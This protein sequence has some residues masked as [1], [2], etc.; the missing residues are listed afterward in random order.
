M[1]LVFAL[2]LLIVV[3]FAGWFCADMGVFDPKPKRREVSIPDRKQRFAEYVRGERQLM[4]EWE[5]AFAPKPKVVAS[6]VGP[7]MWAWEQALHD[8]RPQR[9]MNCGGPLNSSESGWRR[10]E[11]FARRARRC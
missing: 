4:A 7:V 10:R 9:M 1:V 3:V 11:A 5:E 6:P 2:L 8:A